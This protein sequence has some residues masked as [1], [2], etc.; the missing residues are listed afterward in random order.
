MEAA[1]WRQVAGGRP[2]S[3]EKAMDLALL[4]ARGATMGL[5][6]TKSVSM[7][8]SSGACFVLREVFLLW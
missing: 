3:H 5:I 6:T 4:S 8:Y 1:G 2:R 7:T